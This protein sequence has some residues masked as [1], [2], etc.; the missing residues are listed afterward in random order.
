[1]K[2]MFYKIS[3]A[4]FI[5][6]FITIFFSVQS[7]CLLASMIFFNSGIYI[8]MDDCL[9]LHSRWWYWGPNDYLHSGV[10]PIYTA[11]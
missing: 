4:F 2:L 1:M 3:V 5:F 8:Q 10:G 9:K 6:L 7:A 11:L